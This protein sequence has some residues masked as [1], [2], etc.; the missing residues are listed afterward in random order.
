MAEFIF[1][2]YARAKG[3]S[4]DFYVESAAVSYEEQG[5][6]IYPPA[7]RCLRNHGV[8]FDPAKTARRVQIVDYDRFDLLVCMDR[9]NVRNLENLVGPDREHK[10]CLLMSFCGGSSRSGHAGRARDVA[11]PWYT[12]D[13][14]RTFDDILCAVD[15]MLRQL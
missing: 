1:K 15:C 4:G 13:F 10:V 2:A 14:N 9:S 11:D 12:G 8:V 5:N 3:R 7:Q 6:P